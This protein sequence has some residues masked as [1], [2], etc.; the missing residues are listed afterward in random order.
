MISGSQLSELSK[1]TVLAIDSGDLEV[2]ERWSNTG[3]ISDAT[4]NPVFVAQAGLS[5]DAR[6]G[7]LVDLASSYAKEN[8][9]SAKDVLPLA[10]DR[11]AVE[12]GLEIVKLVP[13]Y[14]ST[15][16]DIRFSYDTEE[17][18]RRAR[19]IIAMYEAEGVDRSRI[20]IKVAGTCEGIDAA[21]ILEE[22]GITCNVTLV[23]GL[24]QAIYAAQ[25]KATL[26]SPFP[27]RIL[28]FY[29]RSPDETFQPDQDPGVTCVKSI[30]SY[31]KN[32]DHDT[33]CMPASWRPSRGT[34]DPDFA[35]DEIRALAGVDRMTIPPNLLEQLA[36]CDQPLTRQLSP[37]GAL[38]LE[39]TIA[40]ETLSAADF[41]NNDDACVK[42]KLAEGIDAFTKETLKLETAM[43]KKLEE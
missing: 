10:M 4:T 35:L 21:R 13:G 18:L 39:E 1:M 22:E 5:G 38:L 26:V 15:E 14:V 29:K 27:G 28:D 7:K 36:A 12:L 11:L 16:V 2:I 34:S 24:Y 41:K 32:N 30:Y 6:Y 3:V 20:L 33:I 17:T 42:T 31:Y 9:D 43:R 8:A 25:A 40:P 19:R 23:F 37:A